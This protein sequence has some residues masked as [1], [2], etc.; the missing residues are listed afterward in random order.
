MA[1]QPMLAGAAES[2]TPFALL[3]KAIHEL[4]DPERP[5]DPAS[6]HDLARL[7]TNGNILQGL[8][9]QLQVCRARSLLLGIRRAEALPAVCCSPVHPWPRGS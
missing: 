1:G 3:I 9:E 2:S 6:T 5:F 4:H 7:A 8:Q